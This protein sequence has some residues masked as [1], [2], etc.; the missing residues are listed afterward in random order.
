[1]DTLIDKHE[2]ALS[3][4]SVSLSATRGVN[5]ED[6]LEDIPKALDSVEELEELSSRLDDDYRKKQCWLMRKL[7]CKASCIDCNDRHQIQYKHN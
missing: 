1:M 3:I 5:N 6:I 7:K 4:L 2:E